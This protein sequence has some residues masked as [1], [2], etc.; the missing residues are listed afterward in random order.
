MAQ[1][2]VY[3]ITIHTRTYSSTIVEKVKKAVQRNLNCQR[4]SLAASNATD[5][6]KDLFKV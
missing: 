1:F 6:L 4:I 3:N 5:A 2:K